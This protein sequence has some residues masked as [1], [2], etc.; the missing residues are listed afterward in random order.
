MTPETPT[1]TS[2]PFGTD[3]RNSRSS[4]PAAGEPAAVDLETRLGEIADQLT[5]AAA[6]VVVA[7]AILRNPALTGAG[8]LARAT[9]LRE[10]RASG[11]TTDKESRLDLDLQADGETEGAAE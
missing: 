5:R 2:S 11:L 4:S 1:T 8:D 3:N 10:V 7:A 9:R 6:D